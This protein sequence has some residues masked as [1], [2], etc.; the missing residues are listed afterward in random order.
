MVLIR[1]PSQVPSVLVVRGAGAFGRNH[2]RA[3]RIHGRAARAERRAI[4][5]F[6]QPLQH[7][8]ADAF[9]G[10]FGADVFHAENAFGIERGKLFAQ[11][12]A[13]LGDRPDAAP[14]AIGDFEHLAHNLLRGQVAVC[15]HR[16]RIL[17][18]NLGAAFFELRHQ[19]EDRFEQIQRLESAHHHRHPKFVH[20]RLI[21]AVPHHRADMAGSDEALHP[22]R[23]RS[24]D[25]P[26]GRWYQD[27]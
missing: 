19:H 15:V 22:V 27:V 12:V 23:G 16:A 3:Q 1:H 5:R 21:F 17:I 26:H 14:F 2:G 8:G 20:Q 13:A 10:F 7:Q 24:K 18:L 6:L 11:P 4:H 25:Q 9:L